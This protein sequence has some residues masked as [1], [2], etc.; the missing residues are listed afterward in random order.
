[1]PRPFSVPIYEDDML[2]D[3]D[4]VTRLVEEAAA[5][6]VLPYFRAL[7]DADISE[8][9]GP[10]DLVT[11]A[12]LD[13]EAFLSRHLADLLPGSRVLGEEAAAADP[14]LLEAIDDDAPVWIIDPV[15]GTY[16]FAHGNSRFCIIVALIHRGR[17]VAGWLNAPVEGFTITAER[18]SGAF[19]G[20]E[21]LS[22]AKPATL[23]AMKA[24][25]YIGAQRAPGLHRRVKEIRKTLGPLSYQ[26]CAGAEYIGLALGDIHYAIFTK[27]LPWDHAAGCLIHREAGGHVGLMNGKPYHPRGSEVPLL[28]APDAE[29]WEQLNR[30]FDGPAALVPPGA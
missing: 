6:R 3:I 27:Q 16:N 20:G 10:N 15:D 17:L 26:R 24:V 21:R 14:S 18:G 30:L 23:G 22:V 29:T 9:T 13:C 8:K 4:H 1:M 5:T 25:L 19:R 11:Q 28:L 7:A 12:D 2:P